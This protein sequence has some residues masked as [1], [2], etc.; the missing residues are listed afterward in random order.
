MFIGKICYYLYHVGFI[1]YLFFSLYSLIRII[2]S[3][4]YT[5]VDAEILSIQIGTKIPGKMGVR[6]DVAV[7]VNYSYSVAG[8]TYQSDRI[9]I[10]S[11]GWNRSTKR[12][13]LPSMSDF[14]SIF[15]IVDNPTKDEIVNI[16]KVESIYAQQG[17]EQY[18]YKKRPAYVNPKNPT[19]SFLVT[20]SPWVCLL[21]IVS[22]LCFLGVA[23]LFRSPAHWGDPVR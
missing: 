10:I 15:N 19:D 8:K 13:F 20:T 7:Y 14:S 12:H 6:A 18:V 4:N 1:Y 9:E 11:R 22:S 17:H 5:K 2:N 3:K 21:G 16:V 23:Q